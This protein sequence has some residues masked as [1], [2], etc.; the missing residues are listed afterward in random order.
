M[1]NAILSGSSLCLWSHNQGW[2]VWQMC[3]VCHEPAILGSLLVKGRPTK[4]TVW[5]SKILLLHEYWQNYHKEQIFTH[6]QSNSYLCLGFPLSQQNMSQTDWQYCMATLE[7]QVS[8]QQRKEILVSNIKTYHILVSRK[9]GEI[10]THK[11]TYIAIRS[12]HN[13][14][15]DP[16]TSIYSNQINAQSCYRSNNLNI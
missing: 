10:S 7:S 13:H 8:Q 5:S 2:Q 11:T 15:T 1:D 6:F 16:T 3:A 4:G 12:M 9:E 14:V